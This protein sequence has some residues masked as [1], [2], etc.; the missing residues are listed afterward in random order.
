MQ[1]S[2]LAQI[3]DKNQYVQLFWGIFSKKIK[4][5]FVCVISFQK[6]YACPHVVGTIGRNAHEPSLSVV[7]ARHIH[8]LAVVGF[9][10]ERHFHAVDKKV[11][12]MLKRELIEQQFE[13]SHGVNMAVEVAIYIFKLMCAGNAVSYWRE[14]ALWGDGA[15]AVVDVLADVAKL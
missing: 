6:T 9:F 13:V 8:H 15:W 1:I 7:F 14:F 11:V 12:E 4:K 3:Y 10:E 5:L 2:D